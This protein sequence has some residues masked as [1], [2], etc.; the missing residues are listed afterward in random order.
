[1]THEVFSNATCVADFFL[2]TDTVSGVLQS[3]RLRQVSRAFKT[4]CDM[5]PSKFNGRC[6]P[7]IRRPRVNNGV[8]IALSHLHWLSIVFDTKRLRFF[9]SLVNCNDEIQCVMQTAEAIEML[10]RGG[11]LELKGHAYVEGSHVVKSHLSCC[12][13]DGVIWGLARLLGGLS[14]FRMSS[15]DLIFD[16]LGDQQVLAG[17]TMRTA[18]KKALKRVADMVAQENATSKFGRL[19]RS[20]QPAES[21]RL[22]DEGLIDDEYAGE[23]YEG[24]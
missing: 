18:K 11:C 3:R 22:E 19:D 8:L 1:M 7:E 20:L 4:A 14:H 5:R 13:E 17:P 10:G 15:P 2:D 6:R 12:F 9:I 16:T 21:R 24:R 23:I